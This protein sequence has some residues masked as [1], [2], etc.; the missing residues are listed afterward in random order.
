MADLLPVEAYLFSKY[1]GNRNLVNDD[2]FW[3]D[4]AFLYKEKNVPLPLIDNPASRRRLHDLFHCN[5]CGECCKYDRVPVSDLDIQRL[6]KSLHNV[7]DYIVNDDNVNK[8][9]CTN[10][11]QLLKDN[12]CSAYPNR[13]DVCAEFPIQNSRQAQLS[14]G[15]PFTQIIYRLKC[16]PSVDVIRIIM[17]DACSKGMMLLPDLSLVADMEVKHGTDTVVKS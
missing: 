7:R 2:G 4:V 12:K 16:Q 10:G 6:E 1:Y 5:Q 9:V 15:Q 17:A 3:A 14:N 13:P 8:M 11:C